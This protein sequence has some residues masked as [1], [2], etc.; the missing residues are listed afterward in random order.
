MANH[1]WLAYLVSAPLLLAANGV[2]A[3]SLVPDPL[4]WDLSGQG[5]IT[6]LLGSIDVLEITTGVPSG[7]TVGAGTVGAGDVTIVFEHS[8]DASSEFALPDL[9]II[10]DGS[11]VITAAGTIAGPGADVVVNAPNYFQ[12]AN[13]SGFE[14]GETLDPIFVSFSTIG[15]GDTL[16]WDFVLIEMGTFTVVPEPAAACLFGLAFAALGLSRRR[17]EAR[18]GSGLPRR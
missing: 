15:S 14:P 7:G 4:D 11:A 1:R 6:T 17:R 8:L 13:P 18:A 3:L 12:F 5:G 10:P 9:T 16:R 2:S